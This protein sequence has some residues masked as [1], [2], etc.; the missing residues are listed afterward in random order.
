MNVPSSST[1]TAIHVVAFAN[2]ERHLISPRHLIREMTRKAKSDLN[3]QINCLSALLSLIS[4]M[5]S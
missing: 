5:D 3:L 2:F 4:L 1:W